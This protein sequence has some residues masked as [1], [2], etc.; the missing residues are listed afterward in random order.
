MVQTH[1]FRAPS[2]TEREILRRLMEVEFPGRDELKQQLADAVVRPIDDEG[3]FEIKAESG[4]PAAVA[5]R[6]PVE[7]EL[8]DSDGI[9]VHYLLHVLDGRAAELDVYKDDGTS[10]KRSPN[11]NDLR[12]IVLPG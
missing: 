9:A 6:V 12:V 3:S 7:A 5:K 1:T 8:P 11:P 10:V 4:P 2:K